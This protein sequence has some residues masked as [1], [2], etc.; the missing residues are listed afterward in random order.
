M[1]SEAEHLSAAKAD[2]RSR[3]S[4]RIKLNGLT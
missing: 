1:R 3:S 4:R 2:R